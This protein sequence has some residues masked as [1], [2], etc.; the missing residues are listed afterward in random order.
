MLCIFFSVSISLMTVSCAGSPGRT[1]IRSASTLVESTGTSSTAVVM[2]T[3]MS[4]V[5]A[6]SKPTQPP[7]ASDTTSAAHDSLARSFDLIRRQIP[8]EIGIALVPVGGD[9][10]KSEIVLGTFRSGVA[11][12]T[13]KVPLSIAALN[14][15]TSAQTLELVHRAITE[16]DNNSAQSLW[17]KL[18]GGTAAATAVQSVLKEGGDNTTV[19]QAAVV[20]PGYTAFGQT[21]WSLI[22]SARFAAALACM[23]DGQS[24]LQLMGHVTSS[25]QWGLG[26]INVARFKGGWGPEG[27]GYLVRQLG[28]ISRTDGSQFGVA[29]AVRSPQGFGAGTTDLS[30]IAGWLLAHEGEVESGNCQR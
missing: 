13:S 20:R 30:L 21:E 28:V 17:L 14:R 9:T 12:S 8:G 7:S 2:P 15:S 22:S 25:Q 10:K 29:I 27:S 11:W 23:P 1:T 6:A 19:V 18:G 26:Q 16:S 4:S 3:G 24:V 5:R